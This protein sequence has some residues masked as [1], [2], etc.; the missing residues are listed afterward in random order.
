MHR[1][2]RHDCLVFFWCIPQ[3]PFRRMFILF[4]V[5]MLGYVNALLVRLPSN[6]LAFPRWVSS[7]PLLQG[8]TP[9]TVLL[10]GVTF[11][12][13][14]W[15]SMSYTQLANCSSSL[16]LLG[17]PVHPRSC[18]H[19]GKKESRPSFLLLA[20]QPSVTIATSLCRF[21]PVLITSRATIPPTSISSAFSRSL[22]D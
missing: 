2:E 21:L 14:F 20:S 5:R 8:V 4:R 12:Q 15:P 13:S 17:R 11:F 9:R 22:A 6:L 7:F 3:C 16:T 18:L 19:L 10:G 1:D